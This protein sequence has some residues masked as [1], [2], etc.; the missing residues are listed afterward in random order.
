M[1]G[2]IGLLCSS[3]SAASFRAK[4]CFIKQAVRERIHTPF[5]RFLNPASPCSALSVCVLEIVVALIFFAMV[6]TRSPM[7]F[8]SYS[9]RRFGRSANTDALFMLMAAM[10]IW[11]VFHFALAL[12]YHF[13]RK[14]HTDKK[15]WLAHDGFNGLVFVFLIVFLLLY[16]FVG[17]LT[18]NG[19]DQDHV[20]LFLPLFYYPL[21][22]FCLIMSAV[23]ETLEIRA[24]KRADENSPTPEV[25]R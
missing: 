15:P 17:V 6:W 11:S 19:R 10:M 21:S 14:S 2:F 7:D 20:A 24:A 8:L 1:V 22:I 23:R 4:A 13:R 3:L 18:L 12:M 9:S 16:V 25:I 5:G